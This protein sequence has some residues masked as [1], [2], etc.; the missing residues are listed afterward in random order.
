[1]RAD[2]GGLQLMRKLCFLGR[3]TAEGNLNSAKL[4]DKCAPHLKNGIRK[5]E[6]EDRARDR[7]DHRLVAHI[8]TAPR[9]LLIPTL[10]IKERAGI[11]GREFCRCLDSVDLETPFVRG[12]RRQAARLV[13]HREDRAVLILDVAKQKRVIPCLAGHS[14]SLSVGTLGNYVRKLGKDVERLLA[15]TEGYVLCMKS[16]VAHTSVLAV[17]RERALPV[18]RFVQ[19]HIA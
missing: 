13:H 1:M 5:S 11:V 19:V 16:E 8:D 2:R 4:T 6:L 18:D 14:S 15:H 17:D 10:R 12:T 3:Y 7:G 9:L